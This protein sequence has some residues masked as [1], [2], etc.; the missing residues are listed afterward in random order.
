MINLDIQL[1]ESLAGILN[2]IE[3]THRCSRDS[4]ELYHVNGT[5][6]DCQNLATPL[7]MSGP[8]RRRQ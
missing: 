7:S 5:V 1:L 8:R 4:I 6:T 3:C 2:S